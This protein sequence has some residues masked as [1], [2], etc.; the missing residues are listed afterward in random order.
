MEA[1]CGAFWQKAEAYPLHDPPFDD[2]PAQLDGLAKAQLRNNA[3]EIKRIACFAHNYVML[4]RTRNVR[5]D[6]ERGVM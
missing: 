1:V 5:G 3:A 6:S 2:C 4:A